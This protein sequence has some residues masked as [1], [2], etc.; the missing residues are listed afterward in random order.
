[1]ALALTQTII[2]AALTVTSAASVGAQTP[3]NSPVEALDAVLSPECRVPGGRLYTLAPLKAVRAVLDQKRALKVLALGSAGATAGVGSST[4]AATY[5]VR[6]EGEL[7]KVMP[8]IAV[9]VEQ[10]ELPGEITA[11]ALERISGL[12]AEVE[13]DLIVWQVGTNDALAKADLDDFSRALN[14]VLEWLSSHQMDVVLIEPPYSA[15]LASDEHYK[16]L[17][18][19]IQRSARENLV[20]LVLRFEAMEYLGQ[21]GTAKDESVSAQRPRLAMH[22]RVRGAHGRAFLNSLRHT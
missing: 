17:M 7:Q 20:P 8:S 16:A 19:A 5:S 10:R 11:Q 18:T 13:P 3:P 2:A 14:E 6:L 22:R 15:A 9:V 4:P 12:V 1:M 21:Q